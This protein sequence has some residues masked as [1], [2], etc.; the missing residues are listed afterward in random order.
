MINTACKK[1]KNLIQQFE[2][3]PP[4]RD[5]KSKEKILT[6]FHELLDDTSSLHAELEFKQ[7]EMELLR[8]NLNPKTHLGFLFSKNKRMQQM[9]LRAERYRSSPLPLLILGEKGSGKEA[10]ARV[11]HMKGARKGPFIAFNESQTIDEA[12]SQ[13]FATLYFGDVLLTSQ[14]TQNIILKYLDESMRRD[15]RIVVSTTKTS[16]LEPQL[17]QRIKA[18]SLTVV[19]LRNRKEDILPLMDFFIRE[20]SRNEKNIKKF[21]SSALNKLVDYDWPGNVSELKLELK[22]ILIDHP[23][24]KQ[25]SLEILPEKIIG[26]SLKEL[27]TIIHEQQTLPRAMEM[28]EQ[29]M[30]IESLVKHDWNKSKVSRELGIS[31]SGLIQKVQK[32]NL[33]PHSIPS[34]YLS[35]L[36]TTKRR[37][38]SRNS[39]LI[40]MN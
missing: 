7:R 10:L 2:S 40:S 35:K 15:I 34:S 6:A 9:F 22:R 29:N 4:Q 11:L 28:L 39:G 19:P 37:M 30:V 17:A 8:L 18:M 36:S 32:Y 26:A 27:Y 21:T 1:I 24:K 5:S 20:Y 38:T 25:Y 12:L 31:R 16:E 33:K 13:E 23:N 3:S 14:K